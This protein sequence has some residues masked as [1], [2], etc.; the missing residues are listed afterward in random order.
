[1]L[2]MVIERFKN[3]DPR[4]VGERFRQQ[5]RTLPEGVVYQTSWIDPANARCYQVLE[6]PDREALEPWIGYW[7]D[8]VE[9]EVVPVVTS[10]DYWA[11]GQAGSSP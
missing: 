7:A 1:M 4:P 2:F 11:R 5:G 8:L 9:F 3:N 10:A 6:A